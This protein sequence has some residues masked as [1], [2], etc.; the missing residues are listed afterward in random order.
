MIRTHALNPSV[1]A[2]LP[3]S[4]FSLSLDHQQHYRAKHI[5]KIRPDYAK[6][7]GGKQCTKRSRS[8][9]CLCQ[10]ACLLITPP[11][12]DRNWEDG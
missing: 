6:H 11:L 7:F 12:F 3:S 2:D 5:Q 1:P 9:S 10:S 4:R 8:Q